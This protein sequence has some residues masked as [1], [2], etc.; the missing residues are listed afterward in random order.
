[1]SKPFH[2][3][4]LQLD[5]PW[6][7]KYRLPV[8]YGT[9]ANYAYYLTIHVP[10]ENPSYEPDVMAPTEK[11]AEI[12]ASYKDFIIARQGFRESFLDEL[13]SRPVDVD[14]GRFNTKCFEKRINGNWAYY[15]QTWRHGPWPFW[16]ADEQYPDLVKLIDHLEKTFPD[17]WNEW[18]K[19]HGITSGL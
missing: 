9:G 16:N 14:Y 2:D 18:K 10:E 3:E 4:L 19:E 13:A 5:H 1:M 12:L 8:V 17:K 6:V 7:K 15:I 11:E